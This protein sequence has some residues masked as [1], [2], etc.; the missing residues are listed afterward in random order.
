MYNTNTYVLIPFSEQI[1][2]CH[3]RF[4][5]KQHFSTDLLSNMRSLPEI[6]IFGQL[7]MNDA[8]FTTKMDSERNIQGEQNEGNH[9][10]LTSWGSK[11]FPS[12]SLAFLLCHPNMI[13][14]QVAKTQDGFQPWR[15]HW[16]WAAGRDDG[17]HTIDDFGPQWGTAE[18]GT[19][20]ASRVKL[21]NDW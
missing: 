6:N 8:L 15:A 3:I 10:I 17:A 1:L 13:T 7:G 21:A 5:S 2:S 11:G 9:L 12:Y 4:V 14:Y 20:E 18:K 19:G 16:G